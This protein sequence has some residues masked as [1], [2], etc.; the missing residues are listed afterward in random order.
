MPSSSTPE[1]PGDEARRLAL[2]EVE[3]AEAILERQAPK[4]EAALGDASELCRELAAS[5]T[6]PSAPCAP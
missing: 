4:A 6:R 5:S 3:E 2:E 1:P